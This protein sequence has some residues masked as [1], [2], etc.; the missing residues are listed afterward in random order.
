MGERLIDTLTNLDNSNETVN[1]GTN[2]SGV[3][4][5][6]GHTTSET[7]VNDN[8]NVTGNLVVADNITITGATN[9]LIHT[10]SGTVT[11]DT[12]ITTAV[13]INTTSGIIT[14]HA[15]A[16]AASQNVEFTVNNSTVT[17]TSV[18]LVSVQDE[19]T[20]NH[21]QIVAATHTH[22]AGSFIISLG[23]PC[24]AGASSATAIKVH[25]LIIN[26]S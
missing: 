13:T 26:S 15:T 10:N 19:N 16:I 7:T 2:E 11:Q 25:F 24:V 20:T 5:S 17:A 23:N 1:I 6:I 4:V 22:G 12:D 8:L 9:G 18:I 14:V 3:A 21:A